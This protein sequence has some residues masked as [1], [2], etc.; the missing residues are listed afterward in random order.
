MSLPPAFAAEEEPL[1]QKLS[2]A[3]HR[4]SELSGF[5]CRFQQSIIY[6]DGSKQHYS[7]SLAVLPPDSFRWQYNL[8]YEQLIVSNGKKLWHYEPDLMQV[9][10]L[11]NLEDVDPVVMQLL[12]GQIQLDEL[13]LL[14]HEDAK[15]RY[16]IRIKNG[17]QV[18]LGLSRQ[19]LITY[20]ETLDV[21]ANRN[22]IE[23][24]AWDLKKPALDKFIFRVPE[25]VDI[26]EQ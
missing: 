3:I 9:R 13:S 10:I 20:I 4:I 7:G 5:S 22:R 25:G 2:D 6:S 26:V 1:P 16:S 21:L 14:E 8:P 24:S 17:P 15:G 11:R 12:A 23:L 18:W 19:G